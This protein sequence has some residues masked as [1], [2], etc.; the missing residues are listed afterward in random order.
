MTTSSLVPQE[1]RVVGIEF[2]DFLRG[3]VELAVSRSQRA[4]A[5]TGA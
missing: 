4:V 2:R 1:L 3:Q 5:L